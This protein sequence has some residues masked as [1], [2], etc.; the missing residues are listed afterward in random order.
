[1]FLFFLTGKQCI[2]ETGQITLQNC[3]TCWQLKW[4]T[5][6]NWYMDNNSEKLPL[7]AAWASW[8]HGTSGWLQDS[9]QPWSETAQAP[10]VAVVY[11]SACCTGQAG[12]WI[13]PVDV[14]QKWRELKI[15]WSTNVFICLFF[16]FSNYKLLYA[17]LREVLSMFFSVYPC[18]FSM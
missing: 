6:E 11:Q 17:F 15:V 2:H 10:S 4:R 13:W 9:H 7:T 5:D 12:C 18:F 16:F 8:H 1:M 3:I 14:C